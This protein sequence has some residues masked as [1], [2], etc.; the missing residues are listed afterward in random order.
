MPPSRPS[1]APDPRG[2]SEPQAT[3]ATSTQAAT[4]ADASTSGY[5]VA[6][7]PIGSLPSPIRE[8]A[9]FRTH[10]SLDPRDLRSKGPV[11]ETASSE[12][13]CPTRYESVRSPTDHAGER[14][15][16]TT[17]NPHERTSG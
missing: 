15:W 1:P 14:H 4:N 11:E 10:G 8:Q 13:T 16:R 7:S 12:R 5:V 9:S 2:A 3:E 6:S 17:G